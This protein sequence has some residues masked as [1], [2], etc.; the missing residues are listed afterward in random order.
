MPKVTINVSTTAQLN[1]VL[2]TVKGGETI[3]LAPGSYGSVFVSSIN[4]NATVTIASADPNND[5]KLYSLGI[6]RSS[7]FAVADIDIQRTLQPGE[8]VG[9]LSALAVNSSKNISIT[10]VDFMGSLDNNASNDGLG[11]VVTG[12]ERVAIVDSTFRQFR[13]A[14]V[15]SLNKDVAFA[16]NTITETR[17]GVSISGLANGLFERNLVKDLQPNYVAGDHP[18]AFQVQT[19]RG[20]GSSDLLFRDNVILEGKAG[21]GVGGF[22]IGNERMNEGV[23]HDD[24][25]IV[26][27]F[28]QG[29]Y[30]HAISVSGATDVVIDNNT[31]LDSARSGVQAGINLLRVDNARVTDNLAPIFTTSQS[32]RVTATNNIDVWDAR[33]NVGV[34]ANTLFAAGVAGGNVSAPVDL[35]PLAGGLAGRNG[36]GFRGNGAVGDLGSDAHAASIAAGYMQM[37]GQDFIH[38]YLL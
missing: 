2:K 19:S 30:R 26:N 7:N 27:N 23:R 12:S 29:T 21:G 10:G 13:T 17:E 18:D 36:V 35:D 25:V 34:S 22:F 32:T 6:T 31:V 33:S 16:G 15:I 24:I 37:F 8:R 20:G 38:N 1:A 28:Y 3:L 11:V 4:P 9:T 14:A 5:A